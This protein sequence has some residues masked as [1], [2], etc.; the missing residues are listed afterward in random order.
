MLGDMIAQLS[1]I[2]HR[3]R[4]P[5][6]GTWVLVSPHRAKRPWQGRV[7]EARSPA[8]PAYDP[9]CY[10]CPGNERAGAARNPQYRGP[11]V[12]DNDFPAL[13]LDEA[14]SGGDE[15]DPL[16]QAAPESGICR[17]VCFSER[18]DRHMASLSADEVD[19]V[20]NTWAD[21]SEELGSRPDINNVQVFENRG[22]LMGCSNPHPHG[23]IWA[24]FGLPNEARA[25]LSSQRSWLSEH[26]ECLLCRTAEREMEEGARVVCS[27]DRF[28]A[29]VPFWAVWPFETLLLPRFHVADIPALGEADRKELGSILGRLIAGYDSLFGVPFPYSMGFHQRPFDGDGHPEWHLHAHFFPPLL[30]SATVRKF[31]VG[32]ELCAEP[33]RDLTPEAAAARLR[34]LCPGG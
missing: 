17:V 20:V 22:A 3:R 32:Y 6:N 4:N 30:R 9:E 23:Q 29:M 2:P 5:L 24:T 10:L 18:H 33:Q 21:Q 28:V 16:F 8:P 1:D 31:M 34:L 13:L 27:N 12:F 26:G 19:A 25:E 15:P 11:Y 14:P 7:E